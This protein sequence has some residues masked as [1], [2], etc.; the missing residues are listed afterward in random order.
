MSINEQI[1]ALIASARE[2]GYLLDDIT[3]EIRIR[4]EPAGD[5]QLKLDEYGRH[6]VAGSKH[7]W[8]SPLPI[9][10]GMKLTDLQLA[11]ITANCGVDVT[12][13]EVAAAWLGFKDETSGNQQVAMLTARR[14]EKGAK[15]GE[16]P[17][18]FQPRTF[19]SRFRTIGEAVA[20]VAAEQWVQ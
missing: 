11:N 4:W 16:S 13:T 2:S 12:G 1:T 6:S 18:V 20:Y 3:D 10:L 8:L 7:L 15:P 17:P 5:T 9:L 14:Y 19:R